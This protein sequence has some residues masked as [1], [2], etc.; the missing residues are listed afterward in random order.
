[1]TLRTSPRFTSDGEILPNRS[2]SGIRNASVFPDPVTASTTTSL[3]L[4]N[5]GIVLAWTGVMSV[6]PISER[7]SKLKMSANSK[8]GLS[9]SMGRDEDQRRSISS[10]FGCLQQKEDLRVKIFIVIM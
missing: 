7:H 9:T 1:M 4:R 6:K 5:S 3:F 8:R 10:T 2:R